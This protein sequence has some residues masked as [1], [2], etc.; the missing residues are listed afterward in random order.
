MYLLDVDNAN[1]KTIIGHIFLF[2][3]FINGFQYAI[4]MNFLISIYNIKLLLISPTFSAYREKLATLRLYRLLLQIIWNS[5]YLGCLVMQTLE[6][7]FKKDISY[8]SSKTSAIMFSLFF[9]SRIIILLALS[10]LAIHLTYFFISYRVK[11]L[12]NSLTIA[13]F[14]KFLTVATVFFTQYVYKCIAIAN[15]IEQMFVSKDSQA[16]IV[17]D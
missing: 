1:S 10:G 15:N 2:N 14:F 5:L 9:G 3:F 7:G 11:N 4:N 13:S 12:S 8:Q 16:F 17:A 6:Y